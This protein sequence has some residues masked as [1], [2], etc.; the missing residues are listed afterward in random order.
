MD[1]YRNIKMQKRAKLVLSTALITVLALFFL[2]PLVW[3]VV[4][5]LKPEAQIYNDI[6]S[7]KAF[8]P[9]LKVSEWGKVYGSLFQRFDIFRFILNVKKKLK[10]LL[11]N[12]KHSVFQY[13]IELISRS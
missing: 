8:V 6:T 4:S 7:W 11:H 2:F 9:S 12:I 5:S 3:M 13:V 10:D 1:S